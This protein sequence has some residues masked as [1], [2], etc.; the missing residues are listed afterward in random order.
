[1]REAHRDEV[2]VQY[3]LDFDKRLTTAHRAEGTQ[4][5]S[6]AYH[7]LAPM[8]VKIETLPKMR[9]YVRALAEQGREGLTKS[10]RAEL[11]TFCATLM[12]RAMKESV[13]AVYRS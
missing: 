9:G 2:Y 12:K 8:A 7:A 1:M 6:A 13:P 5:S 11:Y 3:L 4:R 10:E